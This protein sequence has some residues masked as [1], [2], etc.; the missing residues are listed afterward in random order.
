MSNILLLPG[1]PL[2]NLILATPPPDYNQKLH[3][4]GEPVSF[5]MDAEKGIFRCVDPSELKE[6]LEGGEYDEINE[7]LDE[8]DDY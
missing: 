3:S 8:E 7:D 2:F 4:C 6:Y 5:A 1:H